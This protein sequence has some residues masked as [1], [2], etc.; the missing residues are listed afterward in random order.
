MKPILTQREFQQ[1]KRSLQREGARPSEMRDEA[2]RRVILSVPPGKVSTYAAIAAAAGYPRLHRA[3]AR[4]L[5]TD[6]AD[7]L[8]WHRIVGASGDIRLREAGTLEQR[9]RLELE[10][11]R[12]KGK[13]VDLDLH[14]HTLKPWES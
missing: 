3:V 11:V 12:F 2:F 1:A 7:R 14:L 4:L 8:P 9:A 10:G 6:P 5:R 13:H